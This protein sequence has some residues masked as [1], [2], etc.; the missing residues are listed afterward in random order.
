MAP[1]LLLNSENPLFES[2]S[3][4]TLPDPLIWV[5]MS[6]LPRYKTSPLPDISAN[7]VCVAHT[8]VKPE[9]EVLVRTWLLCIPLIRIAPL[10]LM[11]VFTLWQ[12][13]DE[14]VILP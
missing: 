14:I 13:P 4:F 6:G 2:Y 8:L 1:C 9:P 11:V 10:P 7:N 3:G 5:S 12:L